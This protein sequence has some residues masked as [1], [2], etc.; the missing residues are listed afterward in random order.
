MK[1]LTSEF[2][3]RSTV[4]VA[5]DLLGKVLVRGGCRARIVETEAYLGGRDRASHA[6]FGPGGRSSVMFGPPGRLYV[7]LVYGMHHCMNVVTEKDG[8]AGAVLIRAAEGLDG[9]GPKTLSGPGRLCR[10][11]GVTRREN[12]LDLT[13][14][15]SG[16]YLADDGFR[17]ARVAAS[18]RIGVA[19]AGPWA[20]RRLRYYLPG[21]PAV[22][23]EPA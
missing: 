4:S 19:Y 9:S 12:R 7:Y 15:G 6:R 16:L 23:G 21:N 20:R 5:R 14:A 17:P 11:L 22:S 3:A 18:A 10:G 8:T 1:V 2:F 13:D